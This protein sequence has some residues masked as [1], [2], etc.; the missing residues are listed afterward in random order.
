MVQKER[1]EV[2]VP[3]AHSL[4]DH[5]AEDWQLLGEHLENVATLA[6]SFAEPFASGEWGFLARLWHDLGKY[7]PEFQRKL[8]GEALRVEHSGAGAALAIEKHPGH[9]RLGCL[10]HR[11][12]RRRKTE[13]PEEKVGNP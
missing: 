13:Y 9:E 6:A 12:Q 4:P 1:P 8:H 3:Y 7:Q 10:R 5:P 2:M 11:R